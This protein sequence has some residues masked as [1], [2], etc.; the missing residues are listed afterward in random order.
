[1]LAMD[2]SIKAYVGADGVE[3]AAGAAEE[4][5]DFARRGP[6]MSARLLPVRPITI[7]NVSCDLERGHGLVIVGAGELLDILM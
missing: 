3:A 7:V 6:E 2:G 5:D 4:G 1:M